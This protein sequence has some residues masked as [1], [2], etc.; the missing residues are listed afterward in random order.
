MPTAHVQ[1]WSRKG[2]HICSN[3]WYYAWRE[4][5]FDLSPI[6]KTCSTS[7]QWPFQILIL[8]SNSC[9]IFSGSTL[10]HSSLSDE[11]CYHR[12]QLYVRLIVI[13]ISHLWLWSSD[14]TYYRGWL[15][16]MTKVA[17]RWLAWLY[18]TFAKDSI[19]LFCLKIVGNIIVISFMI[20]FV[21]ILT[22]VELHTMTL[23]KSADLNAS[24]FPLRV[25]KSRIKHWKAVSKFSI[26]FSK[27]ACGDFLPSSRSLFWEE[28][29]FSI[30]AKRKIWW[31]RGAVVSSHSAAKERYLWEKGCRNVS[32]QRKTK[33][34][35]P[36]RIFPTEKKKNLLVFFLLSLPDWS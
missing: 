28:E 34:A 8:G 10:F 32:Q 22:S 4:N 11:R 24:T 23:K 36:G 26:D 31:K 27:A 17:Q 2:Q 1:V 29:K 9:Y 20:M 15:W 5:S 18:I 7:Y 30:L 6:F 25:S 19:I 3:S 16:E 12:R 13:I 14:D 21:P 33:S 35:F